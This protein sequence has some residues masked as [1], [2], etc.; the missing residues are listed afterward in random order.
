MLQARS[1]VIAVQNLAPQPLPRLLVGVS[2]T[3][4]KL[5]QMR[6]TLDLATLL[7]MRASITISWL[8]ASPSSSCLHWVWKQ[9]ETAAPR[10]MLGWCA[11]QCLAVVINAT[12]LP[13]PCQLL[14]SLWLSCS[15][16]PLSDRSHNLLFERN[17]RGNLC[18]KRRLVAVGVA[19]W[20]HL[21]KPILVALEAYIFKN[22]RLDLSWLYGT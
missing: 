15:S 21:A 20:K 2:K 9:L 18:N 11:R 10:R 8:S 5:F 3:V 7:P 19:Y 6:H 13:L 14:S 16:A 1:A 22:F 12:H 17:L 4:S